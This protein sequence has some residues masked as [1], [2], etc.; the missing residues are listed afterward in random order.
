MD[1]SGI[2]DDLREEL[3]EDELGMDDSVAW[4]RAAPD[5]PAPFMALQYP[6]LQLSHGMSLTRREATVNLLASMLGVGTLALPRAMAR[7]GLGSGLLVLAGMA[8]A[9]HEGLLLLLGLGSGISRGG[10][11]YPEVGKQA[12][13]SQGLI[14][15]LIFYLLYTGGLLTAYLVAITDLMRQALAAMEGTPDVP[16]FPLVLL[17]VCLCA[18]GAVQRSLRFTTALGGACA[19]G[20][21][22]MALALL[23]ACLGDVLP[24]WLPGVPDDATGVSENMDW[25]RDWPGGPLA[26]AALFSTQFA[27]H[28]GLAEVLGAGGGRGMELELDSPGGCGTGR[29]CGPGRGGGFAAG[30]PEAEAAARGAFLVAAAVLGLLGSAGY[31]RFGNTVAGDVLTSFGAG[32]GAVS[33]QRRWALILAGAL[34]GLV[35]VMASAF[36]AAPCRTAVLELF[37]VRRS[38][39]GISNRAFRR[40]SALVLA[41][42]GVLAWLQQDLAQ[43]LR[44]VGAWAAG[45][46]AL[47]LPGLFA[48]QVAQR[49]DGRPLASL[50]NFRYFGLVALAALLLL[51]HVGE[52]VVAVLKGPPGHRG[53]RITVHNLSNITA[54]IT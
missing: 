21:G 30:P 46:L 16:R 26:A 10:A 32:F 51:G 49:R 38:A 19:A 45:P 12:M 24:A 3:A 41:T 31:L 39:G 11:S 18:P 17:A 13:G 8:A 29:R 7:T 44:F 25:A 28:A 14:M 40:A 50:S 53:Q 36:V 22:L 48:V 52:C 6:L 33:G 42:C 43:V 1:R 23:A 35:L 4:G 34:Y 9:S 20:A 15:V 2:P 37:A 47:A 5:E 54:R 27:V